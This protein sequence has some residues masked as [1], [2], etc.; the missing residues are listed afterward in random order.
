MLVIVD[1][2]MGNLRSVAKA[3]TFWGGRVNVS[4]DPKV[5]A[6]AKALV[7]PG[8][9]SYPAAV[10]VL[11]KQGLFSVLRERIKRGIP[12]LGICLGLQLLFEASEEGD[13]KG[14]AILPG[15]VKGFPLRRNYPIP[16][17]G[18][19]KVQL[20]P[21]A[22]KNDWFKKLWRGLP[23]EGY[24]YF[25]HS[26]YPVSVRPKLVLARTGYGL[27]FGSIFAQ[28]R[29]VAVQFHPE[30]SA[31]LGLRFLGNFLAAVRQGE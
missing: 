4:G 30:K 23:D 3:L 27:P 9:G 25:V 8:V 2:G 14:L 12:L 15:R 29:T 20:L 17:M 18:W 28:E 21:A 10:A 22:K 19:N 7:L 6:Q 11:K 13:G 26:Y 24:F 5:I 1:Y 16:H 31:S